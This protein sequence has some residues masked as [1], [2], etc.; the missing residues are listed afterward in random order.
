MLPI[1]SNLL[2]IRFSSA[3][4]SELPVLEV[5]AWGADAGVGATTIGGVLLPGAGAGIPPAV[6]DGV[7][8]VA[9]ARPLKVA[10]SS[11][12]NLASRA[13]VLKI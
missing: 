3:T 7:V 8:P 1:S 5:D 6:P 4:T 11:E 10:I 13:G 9:P 12:L 2:P